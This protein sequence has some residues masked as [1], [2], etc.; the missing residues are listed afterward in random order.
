MFRLYYGR[1]LHYVCV[2]CVVCFLKKLLGISYFS[3][4]FVQTSGLGFSSSPGLRDWRLSFK[5]NFCSLGIDFSIIVWQNSSRCVI[6][7]S[8]FAQ[9]VSLTKR[10]QIV[11]ELISSRISRVGPFHLEMLQ[12]VDLFDMEY[13]LIYFLYE[14]ICICIECEIIWHRCS[15]Y[16]QLFNYINVFV[17]NS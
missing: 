7:L 8:C 13:S 9:S 5:V 15:W 14:F 10:L 2:V 1:F 16:F 12:S 3:D 4:N 17:V 11:W 6:G